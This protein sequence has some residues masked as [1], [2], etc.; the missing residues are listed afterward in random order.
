MWKGLCVNEPGK[1][2]LL[3]I[4]HLSICRPQPPS[5]CPDSLAS[6]GSV[7]KGILVPI[8]LGLFE[9]SECCATAGNE[10]WLIGT[11]LRL[12]LDFV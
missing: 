3:C 5:V 2:F 4:C 1:F 11:A 6:G 12:S 7:I 8:T 9:R 10:L